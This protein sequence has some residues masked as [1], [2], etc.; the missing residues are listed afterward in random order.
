MKARLLVEDLSM[1]DTLNATVTSDAAVVAPIYE[2]MLQRAHG[3]LI[4]GAKLDAADMLMSAAETMRRF[5]HPEA[6]RVANW[7][8]NLLDI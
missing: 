1:A 4:S 5:E 8:R 6:M 3:L 7:A 2:A